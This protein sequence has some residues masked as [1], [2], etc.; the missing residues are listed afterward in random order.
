MGHNRSHFQTSN[1]LEPHTLHIRLDVDGSDDVAVGSGVNGVSSVVKSGVGRYRVALDGTYGRI[2]TFTS[3][4]QGQTTD[5][6]DV[7]L[8]DDGVNGISNASGVNPGDTKGYIDVQV[9]DEEGV[10]D[11]T[12]HSLFICVTLDSSV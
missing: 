2:Q 4:A 6:Y 7:K 10:A 5:S 3:S 1:I 12:D 9:L 11:P 8:W